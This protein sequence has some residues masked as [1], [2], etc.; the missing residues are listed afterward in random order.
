MPSAAPDLLRP[1]NSPAR[2]GL[3]VPVLLILAVGVVV[4]PLPP[5]VLDLFLAANITTAVVILLTTLYVRRP[6]D[7]SAFPAILL[8]TTLMRLVLNIAS[9]RL[10][11]TKAA[12]DGPG[13]A[14]QVILAFGEFVAGGQLAVGRSC[15]SS[16]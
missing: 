5:G 13:A 9:T 11:L 1:S 10:I 15:S 4:V 16:C 12:V 8:G 2:Q 3:L 6:L 7:F 14:G